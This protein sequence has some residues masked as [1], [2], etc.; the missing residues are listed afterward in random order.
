MSI[1]GRIAAA[2]LGAVVVALSQPAAAQPEIQAR[3]SRRGRTLRA[4]LAG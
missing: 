1:V 4:Q 3:L 2:A